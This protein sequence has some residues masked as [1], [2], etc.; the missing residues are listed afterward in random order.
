VVGFAEVKGVQLPRV[1]SIQFDEAEVPYSPTPVLLLAWYV[2]IHREVARA[3]SNLRRLCESHKQGL[4]S[5]CLHH[6]RLQGIR[7]ALFLS[8][9]DWQGFD[10]ASGCNC[11]GGVLSETEEPC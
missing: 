8:G 5:E 11:D 7:G 10:R 9:H 1:Q 4:N 3:S 2:S 6:K